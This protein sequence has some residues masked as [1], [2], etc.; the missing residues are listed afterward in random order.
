VQEQL[1]DEAA[2][3]LT[4][5]QAGKTGKFRVA[6]ELTDAMRFAAALAGRVAAVAAER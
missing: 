4:D 2:L 6:S 1:Y 3:L 5:K